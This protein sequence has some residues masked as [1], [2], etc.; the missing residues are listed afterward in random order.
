MI[1]ETGAAVTNLVPPLDPSSNN[2]DKSNPRENEIISKAF[3]LA[4]RG[5]IGIFLL[6][7]I[8]I[9]VFVEEDILRLQI[10][11]VHAPRVAEGD[12]GDQ[13]LEVL[14]GDFLLEPP[15]RHLAEQLPALH[16]LHHEE[17]F[18][19]RRHNLEQL[20]NVRVTNSPQNRDLAFDVS[21]QTYFHDLLLINHLNRHAFAVAHV[22]RVVNLREC[23][24]ADEFPDFVPA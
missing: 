2:P 18:R 9:P 17:D 14:S 12:G 3:K 22:P 5:R 4:G 6:L 23:S 24:L 16:V 13:L 10:A 21:D 8:S 19:F 15:L 7:S 1:V 11:V 20:H